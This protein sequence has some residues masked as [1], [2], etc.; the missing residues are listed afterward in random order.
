MDK[1]RAA[2]EQLG[3][4]RWEEEWEAVVKPG[5]LRP[6]AARK[7]VYLVRGLLLLAF[8]WLLRFIIGF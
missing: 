5:L 6:R 1:Y 7:A 3:R 4:K 2:M 8:T